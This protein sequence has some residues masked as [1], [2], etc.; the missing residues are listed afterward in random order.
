[1]TRDAVVNQPRIL[2][3]F[4]SAN[5]TLTRKPTV[6]S[7]FPPISPYLVYLPFLIATA[8]FDIDVATPAS[9]IKPLN[10]S[11]QMLQNEESQKFYTD[12]VP[13]EKLANGKMLAD[14]NLDDAAVSYVGGHG[15]I[16]DLIKDP[17]LHDAAEGARDVD[18]TNVNL[19]SKFWQ[20][21]KT[22]L[23]VCHGPAALV[24]VK[25]VSSIPFQSEYRIVEHGGKFEK[26][27]SW[28]V[29]VGVDA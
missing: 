13:Q 26:M 17:L 29:K 10:P 14:V 7:L 21:G 1:M 12:K 4:T 9:P 23:A 16:I 18:P 5:K 15:S 11:K 20:Q 19:T 2:F 28:G 24:D 6:C 27:G 22:A 25:K 3:V 8:H